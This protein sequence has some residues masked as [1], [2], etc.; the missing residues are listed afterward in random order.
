[1]NDTEMAKFSE[2]YMVK[3]E[4]QPFHTGVSKPGGTT[5]LILLEMTM[6]LVEQN[7]AR[8][9]ELEGINLK[10]FAAPVPAPPCKAGLEMMVQY[11][12]TILSRCVDLG[13]RLFSRATFRSGL[14]CMLNRRARK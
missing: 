3:W 7:E 6:E 8:L 13:R 11:A 14:A 10:Q 4:G 9:R 5:R 1:M 2:M 12:K